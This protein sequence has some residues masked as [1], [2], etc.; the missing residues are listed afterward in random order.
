MNEDQPTNV[1]KEEQEYVETIIT[2]LSSG[3]AFEDLGEI[4]FDI[5]IEED[6]LPEE[7]KDTKYKQDDLSEAYYM[8]RFIETI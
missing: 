4:K 7:M 6:A 5:E 2:K 3:L 1:P 8:G